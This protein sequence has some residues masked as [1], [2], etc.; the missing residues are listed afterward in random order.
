MRVL[1]EKP[2]RRIEGAIAV[3]DVQCVLCA[4]GDGA[5]AVVQQT[6]S[7]ERCFIKKCVGGS[8]EERRWGSAFVA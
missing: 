8:W 1:E 5:L 3:D 2:K 6:L 4:E 7:A